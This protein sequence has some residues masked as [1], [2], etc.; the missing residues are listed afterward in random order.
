MNVNLVTEEKNQE[1]REENISQ[2]WNTS[3][4]LLHE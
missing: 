3:S 2:L 4:G 1:K